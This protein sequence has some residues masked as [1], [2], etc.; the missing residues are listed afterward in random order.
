M[1]LPAKSDQ[2]QAMTATGTRPVL[3]LGAV[4]LLACLA[5]PLPS[6]AGLLVG[7][8]GAAFAVAPCIAAPAA[9]LAWR[10]RATGRL[11]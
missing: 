11:E 8:G 7:A 4:M 1:C 5:G 10:R 3:G 6:G 9:I 2:S